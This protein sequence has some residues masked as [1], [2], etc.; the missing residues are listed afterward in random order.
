MLKLESY[1][2]IRCDSSGRRTG[3]VVIRVFVLDDNYWYMFVIKITVGGTR[4]VIGCLYHSPSASDPVFI[5]EFIGVCD[6]VFLGMEHGI[7]VGCSGIQNFCLYRGKF[8]IWC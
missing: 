5:D 7:L 4:W 1:N 6:A 2:C 3:G 8:A